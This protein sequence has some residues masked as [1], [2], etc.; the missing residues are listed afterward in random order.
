[1]IEHLVIVGVGSIGASVGMG[2]RRLG[3]VRHVTGIGR[4]EA[5]L[6][7][8]QQRGAIDHYQTTINAHINSASVIL[9]T[10]PMGAMRTVLT[11]IKPHLNPATIISDGGSTKTSM[12]ADVSAVLGD[13]RQFVGAHPISGTEKSGAAAAMMDL[14]QNRRVIITPDANSNSAFVELIENMW[15]ALGAKVERMSCEHH[16]KV[17]A[18]TSHLP[19]MLAYGLVDNLSRFAEVDEVFRYAAGGFRDFT[20]IA[21]SDPTMWRDICIHNR[22]AL[23]AALDSY[24]ADMQNIYAA[25]AA[26]DAETLQQVFV[27]AKTTRDH[28]MA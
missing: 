16:D 20:R 14:F 7:I 17:L 25:V 3:L 28:F 1:M 18:A 22:D 24:L 13:T 26:G 27:N 2:L 21:S 5:N 10:V 19:H 15:R 8:A 23:L 4:S 9:L 11:E 6:K 12:L